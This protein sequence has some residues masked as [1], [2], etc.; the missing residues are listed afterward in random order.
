LP[1]RLASRIYRKN[2][3]PT[4]E[5][6]RITRKKYSDLTP[7][8]AQYIGFFK[9]VQATVV[10]LQNAWRNKISHAQ[11]RLVVMT[12]DFSPKVAEEIMVASRGFMRRLATTLPSVGA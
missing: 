8:E 6:D 9:Q 3:T 1:Q 2:V 12:A 4:N 11:G 10:A 7:L 5:L